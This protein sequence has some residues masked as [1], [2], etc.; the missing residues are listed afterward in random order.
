MFFVLVLNI[1]GEQGGLINLEIIVNSIY[2][3]LKVAEVKLPVHVKVQSKYSLDQPFYSQFH[4]P[5]FFLNL[6]PVEV[7]VSI[8]TNLLLDL[9]FQLS[10]DQ[11]MGYFDA[12]GEEAVIFI[13]DVFDNVE[14]TAALLLSL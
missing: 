7:L 13:D 5:L 4:L 1:C 8:T 9:L 3:E 14:V 10:F 2:F 11:I 12:A 6:Y